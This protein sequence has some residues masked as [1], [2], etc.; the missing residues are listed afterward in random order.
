MN[1]VADHGGDV[2]DRDFDQEPFQRWPP[3]VL[4]YLLKSDQLTVASEERKH[5]SIVVLQCLKKGGRLR[6]RQYIFHN[7]QLWTAAEH[8]SAN[9]VMDKRE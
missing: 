6:E 9:E 3:K 2:E 1:C 4:E 5:P 7:I 8:S